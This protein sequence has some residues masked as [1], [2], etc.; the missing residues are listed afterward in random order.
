MSVTEGGFF[1]N[2]GVQSVFIPNVSQGRVLVGHSMIGRG[3]APTGAGTLARIRVTAL[4]AG[5][6]GLGF[7]Q[8]TLSDRTGLDLPMAASSYSVRVLP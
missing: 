7:D 5:T 3:G 4:Q 1:R 6:A 8:A 2:A